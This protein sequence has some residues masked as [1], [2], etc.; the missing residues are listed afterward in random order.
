[1][2]LALIKDGRVEAVELPANHSY[3]DIK[4]L[5]GIESPIDCISRL[6]SGKAFDLWIDDEGALKDDD[7]ITA[8]TFSEGFGAC[9]L[10]MGRILIAHHDEEGNVTGLSDDEMAL[11]ESAM[12][13]VPK[14]VG[15]EAEWLGMNRHVRDDGTFMM[16]EV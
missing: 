2:R 4:D 14:F 3:L 9:E 10:I 16:L 5:L 15:R 12:R 8:I 1:M 6:V 11:V 13:K 7:V